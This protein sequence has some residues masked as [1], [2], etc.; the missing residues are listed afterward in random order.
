MVGPCLSAFDP[1]YVDLE[2]S[3]SRATRTGAPGGAVRD[4]AARIGE[5]V[6]SDAYMRGGGG[7]GPP[8]IMFIAPEGSTHNGHQVLPFR[9]GAFAPGLPVL[10]VLLRYSCRRRGAF[11]PSWCVSN[12]GVHVLRC[13]LQ[14]RNELEVSILP[15]YQ[16]SDAERA[17]AASYAENVARNVFARQLGV[18]VRA[19][20]TKVSEARSFMR[21]GVC[22][23]LRHTGLLLP[24][25]LVRRRAGGALE[26][27]PD[28]YR[29][30]MAGEFGGKGEKAL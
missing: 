1:I 25:E 10:P 11:S 17:D 12:L 16:P 9:R 23:T 6:R 21:A 15:V 30:I 19:A 14:P 3:S 4:P 28:A 22:T 18:G 20:F 29:R 24:A 5:R 8:R 2:S 7:G 13:M 27:D 26:V